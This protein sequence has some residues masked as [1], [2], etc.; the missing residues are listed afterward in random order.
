TVGV[1]PAGDLAAR[2]RLGVNDGTAHIADTDRIAGSV[3]GWGQRAWASPQAL[4]W[5]GTASRTRSRTTL[6]SPFDSLIWNRERMERVFNMPHR[7]EAYTPAAKRVHGYF[8]MPV[9]HGGRL[10]GRVDPART[11]DALVAKRVTLE[12]GRAGEPVGGALEGTARALR[13][14]AAWV[15]A[16]EVRVEDVRPRSAAA[17]LRRSLAD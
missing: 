9:L 7:I 17:A 2:H 15:G 5:L 4:E 3:A 13:E 8:A 10:V 6:L 11:R 16:Q 1:G 12:T 14:A